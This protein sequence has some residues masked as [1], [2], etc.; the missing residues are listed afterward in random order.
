M[1]GGVGKH[2]LRYVLSNL[3]NANL[4]IFKKGKKK[5]SQGWWG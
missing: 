2:F 3:G 4:I 1:I 5:E